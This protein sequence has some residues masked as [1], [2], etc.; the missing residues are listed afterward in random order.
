M[1]CSYISETV[2][3]KSN[4]LYIESIV[5]LVGLKNLGKI[6]EEEFREAKHRLEGHKYTFSKYNPGLIKR[7][8]VQVM[9]KVD[10]I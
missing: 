5:T 10:E 1:V 9:Q 8:F 2:V 6:E 3:I 4:Y 7:S